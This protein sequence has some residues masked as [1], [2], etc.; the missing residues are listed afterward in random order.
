MLY[1]RK[2][3]ILLVG[4]IALGLY[5]WSGTMDD[6]IPSRA[7]GPAPVGGDELDAC[8]PMTSMDNTQTLRLGQQH[9][10]ELIEERDGNKNSKSGTWAY[11][12]TENR[13][14]I[15]FGSET[16]SYVLI[17]PKDWDICI[18]AKGNAGAADLNAS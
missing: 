5:F 14:I 17:T 11:D 7:Q 3:L 6:V 1:W 8:S 10:V 9:D 18:L 4:I 2:G 13:Y 12:Q 16:T 15:T